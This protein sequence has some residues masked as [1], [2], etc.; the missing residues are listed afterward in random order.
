MSICASLGILGNVTVVVVFT[1][2]AALRSRTSYILRSLAVSDGSMAFVC[3]WMYVVSSFKHQ[4]SFGDTG[5]SK[6]QQH[7]C[8]RCIYLLI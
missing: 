1:R 4:W 5:M 6:Y 3:C 7:C 8:T 2:T